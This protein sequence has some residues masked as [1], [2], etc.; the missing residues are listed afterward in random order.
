M[1]V[2]MQV[3]ESCLGSLFWFGIIEGEKIL[4]LNND[5]AWV[6][7]HAAI[8]NAKAMAKKLK[9]SFDEKIHKLH[10]C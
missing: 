4:M 5:G 8:R 9:I 6:R 2:K 10:E 7:K 3:I 1:K